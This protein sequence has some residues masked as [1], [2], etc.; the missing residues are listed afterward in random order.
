[1]WRVLEN[2]YNNA[3]KYAMEGTRVYADLTADGTRVVFSLKMSHSSP[4]TSAPMS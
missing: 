3:A 1:M 4:S 2:I